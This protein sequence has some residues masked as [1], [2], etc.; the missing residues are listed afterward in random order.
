MME[1]RIFPLLIFILAILHYGCSGGTDDRSGN[2]PARE[3]FTP[4]AG[5]EII[6]RD[7]SRTVHV[8]G[9]VEPLR[10]MTIASQMSGTIRVLHVEE[11][12][13][14]GRGDIVATLDVSEQRAELERATALRVRAQAEYERTKELFER[15]LVSRSEY[16]NARADLSVAESEEKLWQTRVDF[17][18]IR[19]PADA[20]VTRRFVEEG[21]AV[22]AHEAIFRITD[23]SMLVVRVGISELDAVHLDRGDEVGVSI[24]AYLGRE[25]SGSI[26]R[27]FPSVEEESRLVT[28][29]VA[30]D[31]IPAGVSVRP[32]NLARLSFT[33]DR[34]ENVIAVP[35]EALLASTRER[36]F[37]YVIEDER[38]IQRDV[39]PGVQR[40]N[41]TEIREGLQ[42]G[43]IIV[44]TNPTNLAEGTKVRVT[45]WRE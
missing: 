37:V 15:D 14:I 13:R 34:R 17:G 44:A 2:N 42:P 36:S 7:L 22:S 5:Y 19:A 20:V 31:D 40:R 39:V 25:F 10:Y 11:G 27:I 38:L 9:T 26:R 35:S 41:L 43:D 21:D 4:V 30:L 28:V 23:M 6:P 12:D 3:R 32:G 18:S 16:D 24:D 1:F 8:S 45:Q 29:E 33:V